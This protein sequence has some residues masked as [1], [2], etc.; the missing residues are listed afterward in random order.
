MAVSVMGKLRDARLFYSHRRYAEPVAGSP[1]LEIENLYVNRPNQN[2]LAL[3]DISVRVPVGTRLALVG[4]NGAGKST[5]LKTIAGLLPIRSGRLLVYGLPVGACHHRV[6]YL[7][8]RGDIDWR[9][10]INLR[11]LVMTGRYVHLG[12]LRQPSAHDW[13]IVDRVIERLGLSALADRQIGQLSGGQQQRAL[14][15]RALA[16]EADLILLDEP[17]SAVDAETQAVISNL[18]AELSREGKTLVVATHNLERLE[19]DFD[20]VLYLREGRQVSQLS[21][22]ALQPIQ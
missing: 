19:S 6:A 1:A 15:A 21:N 14:L 16:Q 17:T 4:P 13:Q 20:G 8:Q 12:W 7:P 5:L 9:F 11:R 2:V 3:E 18:I 10:P 22:A